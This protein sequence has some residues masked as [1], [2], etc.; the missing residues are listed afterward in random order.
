[1]K[2]TDQLFQDTLGVITSLAENYVSYSPSQIARGDHLKNDPRLGERAWNIPETTGRFLYNIILET[3]SRTGLELGTS[4]GY[5]TLW[6]A[7]ALS[8]QSQDFSLITI[9]R[10]EVKSNLAQQTLHPVFGN[11][12]TFETCW[13]GDYLKTISNDTTFDFIFMDA[14][15]GNYAE[16]WPYIKNLMHE[17]TIIIIDNALRDQKSVHE[18]QNIITSDPHFFTTLYPID[19]GL[20]LITR[21]QSN[22][23]VLK[24]MSDL[25][26]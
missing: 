15:R 4:L 3:G 17:K 9:E 13:I 1:M 23:E 8:E 25:H 22:L 24:K 19:N 18:F 11:T 26:T 5:S 12:I 7:A 20:F 2:L 21:Q 6:I 10:N 14:D 16:Y